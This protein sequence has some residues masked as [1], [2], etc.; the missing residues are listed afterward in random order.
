MK[1]HY[2]QS[3][4][5]EMQTNKYKCKLCDK[6]FKGPEFVHKHIFNKHE[7]ALNEKF[8]KVRFDELMKENYLSDPHKIINQPEYGSYY[9]GGRGGYRD[10]RGGGDYYRNRREGHWERDDRRHKEYV[11]YDD[12]ARNVQNPEN[13]SR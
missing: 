9:G 10:R 5:V 3:K 1:Q 12:P 6:M 13:N 7:D 2:A 4:T 8:N 11:D